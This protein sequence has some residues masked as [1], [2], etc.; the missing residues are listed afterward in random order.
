M[1]SLEGWSFTTKLRPREPPVY[2]R[3]QTGGRFKK[4]GRDVYPNG[5]V[6]PR[7]AAL[8]VTLCLLAVAWSQTTPSTA[9]PPRLKPGDQIAIFVFSHEGYSG[10]FKVFED[11]SIHGRGFGRI[12]AQGMTTEQLRTEVTRKLRSTLKDPEVTVVLRAQRPDYMYVIGANYGPGLIGAESG[13]GVQPLT[14][15]MDVRQLVARISLPSDPDLLDV[16]LYRK[17]GESRKIDLQGV[18]QGDPKAWNGLLEPDDIVAFL[19][20]PYM[21]VWFIGP[22]G[23]TGQ[24]RLREGLDIHQAVA[25]IGGVNTGILTQDEAHLL[26]RR[27]PETLRIPVRKDPAKEGPRLESGDVVMLDLPKTIRISIAGEVVEPGEQIIRDDMP[28]SRALLRS[29]GATELGTLQ[30]VLVFRGGEVFQVDASGPASQRQPAEFLLQDNDFVYVQRNDR[31]VYVLGMV[32][33]PGRIALQ[34]GRN[35]FANDMLALAGGLSSKGTLRRVH[36]MRADAS[37]K[38]TPRVFHLDE[39]LKDGKREANP[40]IRPGDILLFGEPKGFT[41]QQVGQVIS[42]AFLIDSIVG[43]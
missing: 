20:K 23:K 19:P 17:N 24:V 10:E 25:E 42:A 37:G 31:F 28:L 26:V 2:T 1:A 41:L 21:R 38:L 5:V 39:F 36:L 14:P 33:R 30:S 29:K 7:L 16:T 8:F 27:G 15:G 40:E 4:P 22:F 3:A 12:V 32:A 35:Y 6:M 11:G 43:G 34:D 18:L 9:P 13:S